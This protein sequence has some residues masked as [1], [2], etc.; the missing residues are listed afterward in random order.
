MEME[1]KSIIEKIKT[2]GVS[3]AEN[4]ASKIIADAETRAKALMESV[5]KE[6]EI[7]IKKAEQEAEKLRTNSGEAIKQ[8]ARDVLIS[9]RQNIVDLF[10]A[11]MKNSVAG[12]LPPEILKDMIVRLAESAAKEKKF[13]IEVLLSGK[14]KEA[15]EKLS[16]NELKKKM[17]KGVTLKVSPKV[18][19]GF[20]IGEKDGNSY[21]DF[22]DEAIAEAFKTY[23]NP[24]VTQILSGE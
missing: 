4:Q 17:G 6:N 3:E 19:H 5:R 10:D 9:L 7:M 22:T 15:L 13:E 21:Y 24:K 2:E 16:L 8:A 14:D 11:V 18:E 12:E 23:L 1:L 20:L